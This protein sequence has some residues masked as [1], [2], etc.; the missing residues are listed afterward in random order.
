LSELWN[1]KPYG[2]GH[3]DGHRRR[4]DDQPADAKLKL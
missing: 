3:D 1:L 2:N 4:Q